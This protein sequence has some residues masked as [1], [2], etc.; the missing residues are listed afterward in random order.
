MAGK[1]EGGMKNKEIT[2]VIVGS[3]CFAT[4]LVGLGFWTSRNLTVSHEALLTTL[5]LFLSFLYFTLKFRLE[6]ASYFRESFRLFNSR[7]DALNEKLNSLRDR[8]MSGNESHL[9][10]EDKRLLDDYFN[11]CAEEYLEYT[12]D[13]VPNK[14]W[15]SW[16]NGMQQ[17]W[18]V[19]QISAYWDKESKSDSYYS[20]NPYKVLDVRRERLD[21]RSDEA[22]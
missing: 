20:F 21:F 12:N 9:T 10:S 11:L 19:D 14:V 13:L 3:F 2:L 4:V 8:L 15:K 22:A 5:G 17:F 7:Y 6:K 16:K 18:S 1:L